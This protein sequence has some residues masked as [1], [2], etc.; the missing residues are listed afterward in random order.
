MQNRSETRVLCVFNLTFYLLQPRHC[1][2]F[3]PAFCDERWLFILLNDSH[4]H[5]VHI[6]VFATQLTHILW[7]EN[8]HTH[9][10]IPFPSNCNFISMKIHSVELLLPICW[11]DALFCKWKKRNFHSF[12]CH[13][14]FLQLISSAFFC[15]SNYAYDLFLRMKCI[16]LILN[17][18]WRTIRDNKRLRF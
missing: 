2:Q 5:E 7:S 3:P 17:S 14:T 4:R 9:T 6:V 15:H 12:I 8:L 10:H 1:R 18:S 13:L 16:P 11:F